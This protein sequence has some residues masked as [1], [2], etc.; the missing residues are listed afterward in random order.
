MSTQNSN[1]ETMRISME[2]M[3]LRVANVERSL[4]FY[5]M[6]PGIEV[7]VHRSGEFA[8][9]SIGKGLLGLLKYGAT[10]IEFGTADVDGLYQHLKE[11]GFP[12]EGVPSQKPWGEYTFTVHDPDGHVLEFDD[13]HGV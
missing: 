13:A 7:V 12:V 8:L 3:T 1:A 6:I 5:Q 9:L 11:A 4:A 2:G 10:H